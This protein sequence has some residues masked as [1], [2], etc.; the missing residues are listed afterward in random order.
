MHRYLLILFLSLFLTACHQS[1]DEIITVSGAIRPDQLGICLEHEHVLV[2]FQRS[3]GY[4]ADSYSREEAL[5]IIL[6]ELEK[7][8]AFGVKSVAE[9]TPAYLGRDV[10]LLKE[11]SQRSGL[12][13][14]TN[15][16][17]YGAQNNRFIPQEILLVTADS[18]AKIWINEFEHGI[19]GTEIRP[20]FIKIAVDRKPLSEFHARLTRA[21]ALTHKATGLTIMSHSGP[22]IAALAQLDI[23]KEE[24]VSPEAFIWVHASDEQNV[25][26][27]LKAAKEGCWI[28]LDKYGWDEKWKTGYPDL[29]V[30]FKQ[31]GLLDKILISQDAGF[32]D[33]GNP[34]QIYRPYTPLFEELLPA[35]KVRGLT[36]ADIR[37]VLVANPA[38]AFTVKRRLL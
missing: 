19:N 26:L 9:C 34:E 37:Q 31:E 29:I 38:K 11:L 36:D 4:Q 14:L 6:P 28:S 1:N 21:A 27:L 3:N 2:D 35:L 5:A 18:I 7:L 15:T 10:L 32:F 20:G 22:A 8:K 17:L 33:P 16:G 25:N 13:I 23:L 30:R 12:H 24:G